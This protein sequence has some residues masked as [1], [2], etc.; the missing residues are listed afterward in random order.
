M[1][2]GTRSE[3]AIARSLNLLTNNNF[4]LR[5][6]SLFNVQLSFKSKAE[7]GGFEP[8]AP[9]LPV[10]L[11]SRQPCSATPAP[12]R[13]RKDKNCA[14]LNAQPFNYRV[15]GRTSPQFGAF[16]LQQHDEKWSAQYCRDHADWNF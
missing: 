14:R 5:N 13:G 15:R 3:S 6:L 8:P 10:Q 2:I 1:T 11:L 4:P 9:V 16:S 7:R 12:L